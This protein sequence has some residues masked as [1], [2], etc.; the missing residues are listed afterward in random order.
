MVSQKQTISY[1]INHETKEFFFFEDFNKAKE[2]ETEIAEKYGYAEIWKSGTK[3]PKYPIQYHTL[4]KYYG[5]IYFLYKWYEKGINCYIEGR[6]TEIDHIRKYNKCEGYTLKKI[7]LT[8]YNEFKKQFEEYE[9]EGK[10][11]SE[12]DLKA[13][14]EMLG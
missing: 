2:K 3:I 4:K 5:T 10:E 1:I 14:R 11:Y 13:W 12:E 7:V 6:K 8:P 9:D